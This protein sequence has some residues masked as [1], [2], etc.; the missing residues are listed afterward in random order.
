MQNRAEDILPLAHYFLDLF[1]SQNNIE[2]KALL[3]DAEAVLLS[4]QWSGNVRE[5]RNLME[6]IVILADDPKISAPQI[7]RILNAPILDL[8]LSNSKTYQQAKES[9][10]KSYIVFALSSNN[11]N[12]VKTA[13]ALH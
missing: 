12:V 2:K 5:L 3:P 10:E 13:H 1:C 8:D 6:K 7:S 9:F 4:H 11:W